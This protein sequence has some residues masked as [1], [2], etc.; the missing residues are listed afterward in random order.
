[1]EQELFPEFCVFG[2][3]RVRISR[4]GVR[5][6]ARRAHVRLG[7]TGGPPA[8]RVFLGLAHFHAPAAHFGFRAAAI[9]VVG[10]GGTK[11][12][13]RVSKKRKRAG[14]EAEH[15]SK[16]AEWDP[17]ARGCFTAKSS[18]APFCAGILRK[19]IARSDW[20]FCYPGSGTGIS[21]ARV[22]KV[23]L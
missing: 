10:G 5:V 8:G 15:R 7:A 16:K 3:V 6:A 12:G 2:A 14:E 23:D 1:M 19:P 11:Q 9:A 21:Q 4:A 13:R 17:S 22:P 18:H 20:E